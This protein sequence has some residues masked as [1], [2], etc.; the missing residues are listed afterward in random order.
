[1]L[2][3]K[4]TCKLQALYSVQPI[5]QEN[6]QWLVYFL[7]ILRLQ[8]VQ[9]SKNVNLTSS[10]NIL[11]KPVLIKQPA[12]KCKYMKLNVRL[13]PGLPGPWT[14]ICGCAYMFTMYVRLANMET[15]LFIGVYFSRIHIDVSQTRNIWKAFC[16]TWLIIKGFVN[17]DWALSI[18]GRG[19]I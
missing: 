6:D 9:W 18:W 19:T 4:S 10:M 16:K 13:T 15:W 3:A 17:G 5:K 1:M 7:K 11:F 14:D 2:Q 8:E 12:G